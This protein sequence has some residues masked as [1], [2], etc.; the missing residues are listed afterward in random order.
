MSINEN[1]TNQTRALSDPEMKKNIQDLRTLSGNNLRLGT[2]SIGAIS[3]SQRDDYISKFEHDYGSRIKEQS[4]G[5]DTDGAELYSVEEITTNPT[6]TFMYFIGR[7]NPP[8]K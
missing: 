2:K 1:N 5:T 4:E 3:E 6:K 7:L 8:H